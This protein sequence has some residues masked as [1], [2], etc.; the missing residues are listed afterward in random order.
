[1]DYR[2]GI[3][4]KVR[5]ISYQQ[6]HEVL[7]YLPPPG[8]KRER[9][10][11]NL[12]AL[13]CLIDE[14]ER[15]GLVRR[16]P[17]DHHLIFLECLVADREDAPKNRNVIGTAQSNVTRNDTIDAS[18]GAC[19]LDGDGSMNGACCDAMNVTP[20]VSGKP[21]SVVEG[22]SQHQSTLRSSGRDVFDAAI[23]PPPLPDS[24]PDQPRQPGE[25]MV[26]FNREHG[27]SYDAGSRFDRRDLWPIFTRWCGAGVSVDLVGKAVAH[28][29]ATASGPVV[30]LPKYVDRM[31]TDGFGQQDGA[32]V[33]GRGGSGGSGRAARAG[34]FDPVAHVNQ[35]RMQGGRD[36]CSI[37][38]TAERVA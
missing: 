26:W 29:L 27:A 12:R 11:F 16:L 24:V 36:G 15:F 13:R 21:F 30:S 20:Q 22:S 18:N 35:R 31:L 5:R 32:G 19:L 7:E 10:G 28:A 9:Q 4:G 14:L 3:V 33:E 34:K 25:W 23:Q 37:D 17:N 1:M 6:L 8:S 38:S 2:T